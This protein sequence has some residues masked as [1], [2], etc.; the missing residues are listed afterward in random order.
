MRAVNQ[1]LWRP[2]EQ[3]EEGGYGL[4]TISNFFSIND[5]RSQVSVT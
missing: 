4:D 5:I 2:E 1:C 3:Q